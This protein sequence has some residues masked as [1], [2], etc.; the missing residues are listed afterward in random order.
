MGRKFRMAILVTL[1]LAGLGIGIDL[2]AGDRSAEGAIPLFI[3]PDS[4]EQVDDQYWLVASG[5]C[6]LADGSVL[7]CHQLRRIRDGSIF[8]AV[9]DP[10]GRLLTI[11]R[12]PADEGNTADRGP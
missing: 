2:A 6:F 1:I 5:V 4:A 7:P 9:F 3:R 10:A 12:D 11:V 8:L